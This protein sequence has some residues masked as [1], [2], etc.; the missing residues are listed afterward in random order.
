MALIGVAGSS[1]F[2]MYIMKKDTLKSAANKMLLGLGH[3]RIMYL[4][5]KYI[6]AGELTADEY[7]NLHKYLYEPYREMGGNGGAERN[8]DKVYELDVK[9]APSRTKEE[10]KGE[11]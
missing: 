3:D 1:G 10:N 11:K 6:A 9:P 4:S 7:E 2:W 5:E 8:M